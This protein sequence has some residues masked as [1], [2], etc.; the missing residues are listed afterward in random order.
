MR[1]ITEVGIMDFLPNYPL[2]KEIITMGKYTSSMQEDI[3]IAPKVRLD[4]PNMKVLF[5]TD[6]YIID[7]L[8]IAYLSSY[9]RQAGHQVDICKTACEDIYTRLNQYEP[10]ILCYSVTTGKHHKFQEL[11]LDIKGSRFSLFGGP[12]CTFS[13]QFVS[14]PGIDAI[15]IGEGFEAIVDIAN[16]LE[17]HEYSVG[18]IAIETIPNVATAVSKN[19]LRPLKDK[20]SLLYPD[21]D[22]IYKYSENYNNPIKNIMCSFGCLFSCP[23]CYSKTYRELY[24]LNGCELRSVESVIGEVKEL[25]QYPLKMIYFQDDV[26]PLWNKQWLNDFCQQY[27]RIPFHVQV[28]IEMLTEEYLLQLRDCGLRSLTFAVECGNEEYRK[29]VLKRNISNDVILEKSEMLHKHGIKFRTENM[30]GL[31]NETPTMI[32]ETI[33]LN[34]QIKPTYAWASIFHSYPGTDLTT[35]DTNISDEDFYHSSNITLNRVQ[36]CFAMSVSLGLDDI[37]PT[38]DYLCNHIYGIYKRNGYARL[39]E[40]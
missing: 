28:R 40:C 21:R 9:L 34:Q 10:D 14:R 36:N 27:P 5:V 25:Q 6:N 16:T 31:P 22:L 38:I 2:H 17:G 32:K 3:D 12:H 30:I 8:G 29:N 11:N 24:K 4:I 37:L 18:K 13:P 19:D 7:P 23:Y 33:K 35:A 20:N 1:D 26:F 15:V 39:Y